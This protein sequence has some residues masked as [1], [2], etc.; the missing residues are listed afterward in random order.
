[1]VCLQNSP[2]SEIH[3]H[4]ARKTW[5]EA[6]HSTHYIYTFEVAGTVLFKD[7]HT[8]NSILIWTG[9]PI[10]VPR[11]CVPGRRRIGMIICYFSF[12]NNNVV[13]EHSPH[14]LMKTTAD[15][16][17]RNLEC[18]PGPHSSFMHLL[19]SLLREIEG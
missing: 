9:C 2:I 3:M 19:E 6:P 4:T 18:I 16:F 12:A 14:S 8:L 15:R 7:W 11:A 5:I 1:M 10:Y 13:R 17:I